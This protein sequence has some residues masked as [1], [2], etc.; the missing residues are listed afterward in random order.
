MTDLMDIR[1]IISTYHGQFYAQNFE[2]LNEISQF[3]ERYNLSKFTQE[4]DT[5]RNRVNNY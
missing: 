1:R 5:E 2:N 4:I 3:I